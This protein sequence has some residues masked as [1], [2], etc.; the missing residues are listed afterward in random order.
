LEH[1]VNDRSPINQEVMSMPRQ[2][3]SESKTGTAKKD[4]TN[5]A[6]PVRVAVGMHKWMRRTAR[7]SSASS[8]PGNDA[9]QA[10][11]DALAQVLDRTRLFD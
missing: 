10:A 5:E 3:S 7:K 1:R 11:A 6:D 4:T 2:D 8:L 9:A